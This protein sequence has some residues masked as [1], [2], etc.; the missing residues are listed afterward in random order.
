MSDYEL[1]HELCESRIFRSKQAM[2]KYSDKQAN[3]LLYSVLLSSIALA[4]DP[5]THNWAKG[6]FAKTAAFGNFDYFRPTATDLYVLTHMALHVNGSLGKT[7]GPQILR[8]YKSLSKG[9]VDTNYAQQVLLRM[10]RALR[11]KSAK[12]RN[13]RRVLM[14]W[15]KST[16]NEQQQT[17]AHLYRIV[18]AD[19]KLAEVLPYLQTAQADEPGHFGKGSGAKAFA[20][21]L[22][23]AGLAGL[24]L[25][26]KYDTGSRWGVLKNGANFDGE[27]LLKEDR[28]TQLFELVKDLRNNPQVEDI[29]SVNYIADGIS[30]FVRTTDGNA[31]EFEIRPAPFAKG[32]AG[33]RGIT[34]DV[35]LK[36]EVCK[37]C[38][39][40]T[41]VETSIF[42]DMDGL[43]HCSVCDAPTDRYLP[44]GCWVY[45]INERKDAAVLGNEKASIQRTAKDAVKAFDDAEKGAIE[46]HDPVANRERV[47]N[48]YGVEL[49]DDF[50]DV[51]ELPNAEDDTDKQMSLFSSDNRKRR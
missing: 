39:E 45:R 6:Y 33:K 13:A 43:L 47:R 4:L 40:G 9:D 11:I 28:P 41:Y 24:A 16:P 7:A 44:E 23:G 20:A 10:E 15:S 27:A 37:V 51:L 26:P 29:I 25:A 17:L 5:K 36:D 2:D 12:L 1:I 22:V 50:V 8:L 30:A 18:R 34:E 14:F 19:A 42:D 48:M 21:A 35:D 31:Y 3:R 46:N 32:H 38:G 49:V